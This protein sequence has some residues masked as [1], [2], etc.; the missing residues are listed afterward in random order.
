[1]WEK[2]ARRKD[3]TR[4]FQPTAL[5]TGCEGARRPCVVHEEVL[6]KPAE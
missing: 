3:D 5:R 1:M 4:A 2:A 6:R